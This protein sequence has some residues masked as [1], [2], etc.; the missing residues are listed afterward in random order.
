MKHFIIFYT[1]ILFSMSLLAQNS[2]Q[3]HKITAP[4]SID[5]IADE[6]DWKQ[7]AQ[8]GNFTQTRPNNGEKSIRNTEIAVLYDES[9]IYVLGILHVATKEEI[10]KQLTARDDTGNADFFAIQID[11]FGETREGYDFTVTAANVQSDIKLSQNNSYANFNVVW[12]SAVKLYDDK[13]IVEFK[14][15][16]NSIRFPKDAMDNFKVN[17]QRVST[18]LNEESYWSPIKP[19]V[20]GFLNQFGKLEGLPKITPPLN[21]SFYPF[22]SV[23]NEKSP[24]GSSKTTLNGGLDVKYVHDNSYTLD[25]SLIPDFSQA[26]SDKQIFN[27]S[28]FEVRFNE[29]RQFFVEGTEIFD[30]G[31]YLYTRRIGGV[32][33][34]KNRISLAENEEI[35]KNPIASNI[36]NLVKIT[37]KSSKGFSIGVL[38]G[39]TAKSE[40]SIQ[41]T[42]TN[43]FRN[44][45]TNPFTNYN[46]LVFDQTLKNNSSITFL[47]NSVWRS[48]NDY[49]SNLSALLFRGYTKNRTYSLY[50]KKAISQKY[51]SDKKAEFGHE[52]YAYL[53]KVS[54]NWTGGISAKL[55]DETFDTNDFGFLP[56]NNEFSVRATVNY[57]NNN[58]KKW[59]NQYSVGIDHSQRYYY[60][61][62]EKELAYYKLLGSA[63]FKNNSQFFGSFAFIEKRQDFFEPRTKDRNFNKPA[64]L[65]SFLEY[66]TNRN[67]NVWFAGYLVHVKTLNSEVFSDE[68]IAGYGVKAQ[69]G[70]HVSLNF[71]QDITNIPSNAGFVTHENEDLIFGRR[72]VQELT[73]T[74]EASYA[75][76]SKLSMNLRVRHY[77]IQV[78]YKDQF[79]LN[80]QGNLDR[81]NYTIDP[82]DFDDNFNSFTVDY[83]ARWQFAPASELSFNYKLGANLFNNQINSGYGTNLKNTVKQDNSNTVSLKMTYFLD[84]NTIR[85]L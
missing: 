51:F 34:N 57:Q 78:D 2:I 72:S 60:S 15:P 6:A 80:A 73:N 82:N 13:W 40:A 83:T 68:F 62:F 71:S 9:Y 5:G 67:K 48:G 55:L 79:T 66:Q 20:D 35:T 14:I 16:F 31:G 41:N 8:A 32:P 27:L 44:E 42:A 74:F 47:N 59:F 36:L 49:D 37:G 25:V 58:P 75:V 70:Q 18:K 28:P 26:L 29:N 76:F 43:E 21:L 65:E 12:E 46:A 19:N 69:L 61:L 1:C 63:T 39:I 4:I 24:D 17:F 22:V 53:S 52:Y 84:Y 56:R 30:K 11:P 77:W 81:N 45:Q 3:I 38:N 54:G 85:K 64:Q 7:F 23:V 50:V 33:I 10:S